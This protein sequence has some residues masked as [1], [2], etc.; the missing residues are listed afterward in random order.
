MTLDVKHLCFDIVN[1]HLVILSEESN[2]FLKFDVWNMPQSNDGSTDMH[3]LYSVHQLHK[4]GPEMIPYWKIRFEGIQFWISSYRQQ[5]LISSS[6]AM[7]TVRDYAC[8]V[9]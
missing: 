4:M 9:N 7:L 8:G 6:H 1:K 3:L 5:D 2:S